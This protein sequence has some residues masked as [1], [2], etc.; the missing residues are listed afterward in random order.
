MF[1]SFQAHDY[2]RDQSNEIESDESQSVQDAIASTS[3]DDLKVEFAADVKTEPAEKS[4]ENLADDKITEPETSVEHME[5]MIDSDEELKKKEM[6]WLSPI[7]FK[8]LKMKLNQELTIKW[9]FA[10]HQNEWKE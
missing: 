2:T 6:D 9:E 8:A 5:L 1:R 7:S 4:S 10:C 3:S